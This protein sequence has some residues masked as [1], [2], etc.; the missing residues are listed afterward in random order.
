MNEDFLYYVW[1]HRLYNSA[2]LKTTRGVPFEVIKPG[3]K[4]NTCGPDFLEA[5]LKINHTLWVGNIEI[6]LQASDWNLHKHQQDKAYNNVIL[7][8]VYENDIDIKNERS[9]IIPAFE[10]KGKIKNVIKENYQNFLR[11]KPCFIPCEKQLIRFDNEMIKNHWKSRLLVE[12]FEVKTLAIKSRLRKTHYDWEAVLFFLL[13]KYFGTKLNRQPMEIWADSFDYKILKKCQ[14]NK[15]A[16]EALF[17]GQAGFLSGNM[18]EGYFNQLKKE[19]QFLQQ[20]YH[21]TPC[22]PV[23]FKFY[24][25][26]PPNYPTIRLAQLAALYYEYHHLFSFLIKMNQLANFYALFEIELETYWQK[27]YHFGKLSKRPSKRTLSKSFVHLVLINVILPLKYC[28]MQQ[29]AK[30]N[31]EEVVDF[32]H[33]LPAERNSIISSFTQLKLSSENAWDSQA[34]IQLKTQYCDLK[35]CLNCEIGNQLLRKSALTT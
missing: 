8:V 29:Q 23:M 33:L 30:Q 15:K 20:K 12:R 16:V 28:Y 32:L 31:I 6:H 21:L 13:A 10:L 1:K 17:F 3:T 7:H 24:G 2:D 4:N 11:A 5:H 22:E 19:Y 25:V 9:E 27:N 18:E 26:R 35:R 34:L 14:H